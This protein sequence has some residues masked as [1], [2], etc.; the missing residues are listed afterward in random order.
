MHLV[1]VADRVL[2]ED[3]HVGAQALQSPV[4]LR[5][6]HLAHQ[7]DAAVADDA[8]EQDRQ[9]ARDAVGPQALLAELAAA[10]DLRGRAQRAVG[11]EHARGQPLEEQRLV[12]GDAQ[13]AQGALRVREGQREG[14]RRRR[15]ARG[16]AGP[17]PGPSRGES[18]MPVAKDSRTKPPGASRM[19]W[20]RL[21]IGSST[22]P[23]VP[24]SGARRGPAGR[25]ARAP[26]RGSGPRSVSHSSG[27]CV[28]PSRL[29]T[30][31]AHSA[32]SSGERGRR[33][34]SSAVRSGRYSVSRKSLPKA[35]WAR[36]SAA[37]ASTISA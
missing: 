34:H 2:V 8:H 18:A 21:T 29:R 37:G 12:A 20:R 10:Q 5:L 17:A 15:W 19:R 27:P 31:T 25:P 1:E 30:C 24:D 6:Q 35:G 22:T 11:V 36:S 14:A 16:S 32:A 23:V 4:L 7:G 3:H 13:V 26:G 9:V 33:L 28:R